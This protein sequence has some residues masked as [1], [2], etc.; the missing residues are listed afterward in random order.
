MDC[1]IVRINEAM[2]ATD[3]RSRE[4]FEYALYLSLSMHELCESYFIHLANTEIRNK[5]ARH[6]ITKRD[7]RAE[8]VPVQ[9]IDRL[10][11]EFESSDKRRRVSLGTMIRDLKDSLNRNQLNWFFIAQILSECTLDRKRA[12][13]IAPE[14]Y[15][16]KV[17]QLLWESWNKYH[18]NG[19][20]VVL[21]NQTDTSSLAVVFTGIWQSQDLKFATKNNALKRVA[22]HDFAVVQFLKTEAPISYLS[23][24]VAAGKKI[25]DEEAIALAIT[26]DKIGS[27]QY[28]LWCLGMLGKRGSLYELISKASS[29]ES[30]MPKEFREQLPEEYA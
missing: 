14:I 6:I 27:F 3:C 2:A 26:A 4:Q 29:I 30:K 10:L 24:C 21:T 5:I 13:F 16:Q 22:K 23:A 18:D 11:S 12:Y 17:D 28:A 9:F 19:C 8:E 15:N 7:R 25:S 1:P 20:M